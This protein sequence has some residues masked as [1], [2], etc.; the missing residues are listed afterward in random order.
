[1]CT[2]AVAVVRAVGADFFLDHWHVEIASNNALED[3][4]AWMFQSTAV[5]QSLLQAFAFFNFLPFN[6]EKA[7]TVSKCNRQKGLV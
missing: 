3:V 1:V 7:F 6:T 4:R 2:K 5:L